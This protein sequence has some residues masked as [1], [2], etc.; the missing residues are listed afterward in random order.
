MFP[1]VKH[2]QNTLNQEYQQRRIEICGVIE[3]FHRMELCIAWYNDVSDENPG[4]TME[5]DYFNLLKAIRTPN[6]T[7]FYNMYEVY[8]NGQD[9]AMS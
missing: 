7:E 8:K 4:I 6:F 1:T 2:M 3:D 9:P 5:C